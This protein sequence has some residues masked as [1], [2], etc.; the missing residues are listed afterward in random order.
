MS[1]DDPRPRIESAETVSFRLKLPRSELERLAGA[2]LGPKLGIELTADREDLLLG[3][4]GGESY[5]RF[6]PSGA[7]ATLTDLCLF[8]DERAIFF[9]RI[10]GPLM[11]LYKGDVHL[12]LVWNIETRNGPG[13]YSEV[14]ILEG[15]TSYPDFSISFFQTSTAAAERIE[16]SSGNQAAEVEDE[17][18][19]V[20]DL[21]AKAKDHWA[22]YQRLKAKKP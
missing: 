9:H 8:H 17:G 20:R 6:R 14:K 12:R 4:V 15:M 16:A 13:H 5:L 10:I 2:H 18:G 7:E 21:L 1:A 3:A 19:E 11:I 22:E